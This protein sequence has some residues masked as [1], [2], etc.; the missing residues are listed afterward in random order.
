MDKR[1]SEHLGIV[2]LIEIVRVDIAELLVEHLCELMVVLRRLGELDDP[3]VRSPHASAG[4]GDRRKHII[5]R[6][7]IGLLARLEQRLVGVIRRD[8]FADDIYIIFRPAGDLD[9]PRL[10]RRE[11][12]GISQDV[13][14]ESG[15]VGDEDDILLVHFHLVQRQHGRILLAVF[16]GRDEFIEDAVAGEQQ[17][18]VAEIG[19]LRRKEPFGRVVC[20]IELHFLAIAEQG[21]ELRPIEVYRHASPEEELEIRP[22]FKDIFLAGVFQYLVQ[23][24]RS[25]RRLAVDERDIF[26]DSFLYHDLRLL[27]PILH[28]R[29]FRPRITEMLSYPW[30]LFLQDSGNESD[31]IFAGVRILGESSSDHHALP[32]EELRPRI[33]PYIEAQQLQSSFEMGS[34]EIVFGDR[35]VFR[36]ASGGS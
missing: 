27:L 11:S 19:I 10:H 23:E 13:P 17:H 7:G 9:P 28:I 8:A 32:L 15:I 12:H 20:L 25:P 24:V 21:L 2:S 29:D 33:V 18:I 36:I 22:D 6:Y 31:V 26:G 16:L 14:P 30:R 35:D 1:L 4:I 3:F 34:P 5:G